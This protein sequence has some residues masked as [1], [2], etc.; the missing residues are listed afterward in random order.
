[1]RFIEYRQPSQEMEKT[2]VEVADRAA[3]VA[4]CKKQL[5][6]W[7]DMDQLQDSDFTV[8]PYGQ[9]W[10]DPPLGR[11]RK[12]ITH[13]V[14]IKDY[15]VMGFTDGD[16]SPQEGI[17]PESLNDKWNE[18]SAHPGTP[19]PVGRYV[20]CD[21]CSTDYTDRA[22]I[23]GILVGSRAIC[24]ACTPRWLTLAKQY[25]EES[26]IVARCDEHTAFADWVRF[27]RGPD[28]AI[29]ILPF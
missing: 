29:T 13:V 24:P 17:F 6:P 8:S 20:V 15:G 28:A 4:H 16:F 14:T 18:A 9:E 7:P 22:D 12:W 5:A 25:G 11:A 23:G 2:Q 21:S 3:L 27:L 1:M 10:I 19:V 26:H